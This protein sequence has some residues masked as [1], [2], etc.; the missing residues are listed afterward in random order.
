MSSA[1]VFVGVD[2]AD[3]LLGD[4]SIRAIGLFITVYQ[5]VCFPIYGVARVKRSDYLAFDRGQLAYLNAIEKFNC[6]YCSYGNGFD[7]L[8]ARGC[9]RVP[10]NIVSY[11]TR[12]TGIGSHERYR[13]VRRLWRC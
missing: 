10:N 6:V 13:Q 7:C 3:H 12:T 8:R 9:L 11:Q 4:Y 1:H 5:S 2:S